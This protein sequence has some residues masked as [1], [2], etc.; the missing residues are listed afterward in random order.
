MNKRE[1]QV[2]EAVRLETFETL[3]EGVRVATAEGIV[4]SKMTDWHCCVAASRVAKDVLAR[5][6]IGAK[7]MK[8]Q[9]LAFND[10]AWKREQ[11]GE[12]VFHL[13]DEGALMAPPRPGER[14]PAV[15]PCGFRD[16]AATDDNWLNG[17]VVLIVENEILLDPSA[18]QFTHLSHGLLVEPLALDLR[19]EEDGRGWV[20]DPGGSFIAA[21]L[22]EGGAVLYRQ[23]PDGSGVFDAHDWK[24]D[25]RPLVDEVD[26]QVQKRV[27]AAL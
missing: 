26:R 21:P 20:A 24:L 10:V 9:C 6:Y 3:M 16:G 17:H 4:E 25:L 27:G 7:A 11:E 5:H 14:Q 2:V 18:T 22:E 1:L 15:F 19:D 12:R 8:V 13:T 23:H